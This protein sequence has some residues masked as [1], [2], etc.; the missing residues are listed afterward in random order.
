MLL[1]TNAGYDADNIQDLVNRFLSEKEDMSIVNIDG[2][3][4]EVIQGEWGSGDERRYTLE[5]AGYDYQA[6]QNRVNELLG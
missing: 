1:L 4:Q 2:A 5:K 3:A 6:V